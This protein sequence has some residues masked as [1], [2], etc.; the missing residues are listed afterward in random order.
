MVI[1]QDVKLTYIFNAHASPAG[2]SYIFTIDGNDYLK[3]K[4]H[5]MRE[6]PVPV[7]REILLAT[8]HLRMNLNVIL[9]SSAPF[10]NRRLCVD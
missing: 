5:I 8:V 7:I 9:R 1:F 3:D 2:V 6:Q 10:L 4:E